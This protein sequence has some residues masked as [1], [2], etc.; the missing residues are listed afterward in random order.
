MKSLHPSRLML[1][2][3][4]PA[5]LATGMIEL[6]DEKQKCLTKCDGRCSAWL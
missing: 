4:V 5:A 2:L 6:L 3:V 1:A